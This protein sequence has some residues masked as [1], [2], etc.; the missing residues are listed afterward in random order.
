METKFE[1]AK[2]GRAYNS[3]SGSYLNGEKKPKS[4]RELRIERLR[5][6]YSRFGEESKSKEIQ[7]MKYEEVRCSNCDGIVVFDK[8]LKAFVCAGCGALH[9]ESGIVSPSIQNKKEEVDN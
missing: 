1:R 5:K 9:Q 2:I 6:R 7:I 4:R 3:I 8:D